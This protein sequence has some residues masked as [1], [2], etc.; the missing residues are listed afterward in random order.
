MS[1]YCRRTSCVVAFRVGYDESPEWFHQAV[2]RLDA[3]VD[4]DSSVVYRCKGGST[5]IAELGTWLILDENGYLFHWSDKLFT[6]RYLCV[7]D[8]EEQKEE[9][10]ETYIS[11]FKIVQERGKG[12]TLTLT[13]S[14][15]P[16]T[17]PEVILEHLGKGF[18]E[19]MEK[20]EN[21]RSKGVVI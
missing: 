17:S 16:L 21:A 1:L 20:L 10:K 15:N 8:H 3:R 11:D 2:L 9:E 18:L 5:S 12:D 6:S 7:H 13:L 19:A 14:I 4:R